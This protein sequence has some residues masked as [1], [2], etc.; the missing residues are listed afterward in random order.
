MLLIS[1]LITLFL[2]ALCRANSR[3]VVPA[4]AIVL[5]LGSGFRVN[6]GTDYKVYSDFF[7]GLLPVSGVEPGFLLFAQGVSLLPYD[8]RIGFLIIS[9]ITLLGYSLFI[10]RYSRHRGLS[11]ALFV[12]LPFFFINSMNL[13]RQHL[14]IA[15]FLMVIPWFLSRKLVR[16]SASM[17][18]ISAFHS[19]S[20]LY[21][22][23]GGF[24]SLSQVGRRLLTIFAPIILFC[25]IAVLGKSILPSNMLYFASHQSDNSFW[26]IFFVALVFLVFSFVNVQKRNNDLNLLSFLCC[27]IA[28]CLTLVAA[29]G[30]YSLFFLRIAQLF[31]PVYLVVYPEFIALIRP[32]LWARLIEVL[33]IISLCSFFILRV[34]VDPS[35]G[36]EG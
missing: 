35:L 8:G 7:R 14:I 5:V 28:F 24:F 25:L 31:F 17:I 16:L 15:I 22:A 18:A 23:I 29:L 1:S 19:A 9:A 26:L 10:Y 13:M 32:Q 34:A 20:L 36:F 11:L 27:E 3:W 30:D 21:L 6:V 2:T 4:V 12:G 33:S